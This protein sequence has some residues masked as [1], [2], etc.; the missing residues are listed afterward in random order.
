MEAKT[1]RLGRALTLTEEEENGVV[2][3][4][5]L[6]QVESNQYQLC[7]V[8]RLLEN[9]NVRFEVMCT[10]VQGMLNLEENPM[11]V[12]LDWCESFVHVHDLPLS[13]MN[14]GEVTV[15][16]NK[17]GKFCDIEMDELGCSW[18]ST[19]R[20][21]VALNVNV[22]LKRVLK[23]CSARGAE[24]LVHFTYERLPNFC[25]LCGKLGH[26][27]KYYELHFSA[28]F[29]DPGSDSPYGSWMRPTIQPGPHGSSAQS[30]G[31][32]FSNSGKDSPGGR[33]KEA[34]IFGDFGTSPS[35]AS[36]GFLAAS[37]VQRSGMRS[38]CEDSKGR[39]TR[40]SDCV[41]VVQFLEVKAGLMGMTDA[42]SPSAER[43]VH[44]KG[45]ESGTWVKWSRSRAKGA[46]IRSRVKE[47]MSGPNLI[48]WMAEGAQL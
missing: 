20:I 2:M 21:R 19:L 9:R 3:A 14:L 30:T 16:G 42:G 48:E 13:I 45:P 34:T 18:G 29:V 46:G 5:R 47:K 44:S 23:L 37:I 27:G 25:Y 24:L 22:P 7:L 6:W 41:S 43:S 36:F 38:W 28:D 15:I 8:G 1:R 12:D 4:E 31:S 11:R 26:I 33:K 32:P 17:L 10:S 35:S 39:E 40:R